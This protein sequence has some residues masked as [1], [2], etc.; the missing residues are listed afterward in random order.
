MSQSTA[1]EFGLAHARDANA[2]ARMSRDLIEHGLGWRWQTSAIRALMNDPDTVVLCARQRAVRG[3]GERSTALP[4]SLP[5]LPAPLER[6]L[7][8]LLPLDP[9][10]QIAG[11]GVM[12]YGLVRAHLMLLAVQPA[13]QRRGIG[14]DLLH[15]LERTAITAGIERIGLEV[16]ARNIA[17]RHFYREQGY[18]EREYVPRYY[19]GVES[20]IRMERRLR[21]PCPQ[22]R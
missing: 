8:R 21:G 16:R 1:L 13:L 19:D 12:Q 14:A 20:A 3:A 15:W 10:L 5:S 2:L 17:A 11:F 18:E 22:P 9:V 4:G 7:A 6:P